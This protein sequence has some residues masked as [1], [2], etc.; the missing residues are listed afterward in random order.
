MPPPDQ[1]N[2]PPG[3]VRRSY[4]LALFAAGVLAF[5]VV[6]F[7]TRLGTWGRRY[8]GLTGVLGFIWPPVFAALYG[9][10]PG[11]GAV[12]AFWAALAAVLLAHRAWGAVL[13]R[14]GR[15]CHSQFWGRSWFERA[16]APAPSR[17]PRLLASA[18]ALAAGL[19][20]QEWVSLPLGLLLAGGAAAKLVSETA[21]FRALDARLR[22]MADARIEAAYLLAQYRR[23]YGDD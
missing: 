4:D 14:R 9:P 5:P 16:D 13:D 20:C 11:V 10:R 19:L 1:S 6:A 3:E 2:A 22:Q 23:R 7:T 18:V 8:P 17:T 12:L 21:A 15:R